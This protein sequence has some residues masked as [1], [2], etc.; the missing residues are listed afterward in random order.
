[1]AFELDPFG[2]IPQEVPTG[3]DGKGTERPRLLFRTIREI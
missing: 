1:V 3:A 2:G